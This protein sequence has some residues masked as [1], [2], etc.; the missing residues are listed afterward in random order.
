MRLAPLAVLL[1]AAAASVS[2]QVSENITVQYV[3][4]PVTVVDRGGNPVRALTK[5][6]FEV[7]DE[8]KKR[9]IAG[10]E[11]VD[12]ASAEAAEPLGS[13]GAAP[14]SPAARRNFLLVF[15]LSYASPIAMNRA[16]DA[17]RQFVKEMVGPLDRVGVATVD[18]AHGFHL[19]TSF[20]TDRTLVASA[21]TKTAGFTAFDPL[22]V[23]GPQFD[24]EGA[25]AMTDG[26]SRAGENPNVDII[27][28]LNRAEDAYNRGNIDRELNLLG[29]LSQVLRAVRGQKHLVLLSE[30]FDPRLIQGRD[31]GNDKVKGTESQN[32]EGGAFWTVDNDNRYG[33]VSSMRLLDKMVQIAKRSDVVFDVVDIHGLRTDIDARNGYVHKSNEALT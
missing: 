2:S 4:V 32:I 22:Q 28:E 13:A 30:G 15:D 5:A 26:G 11:T 8:G 1:L 9:E 23:A 31:A 27:R 12:F 20:T 29:G 10:F 14:I 25:A 3:E 19:L 21:I 33:N 24:P 17:A 6:N 16:K 18:V 7:I